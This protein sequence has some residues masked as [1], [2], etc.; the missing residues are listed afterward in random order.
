MR[1]AVYMVEHLKRKNLQCTSSFL[2]GISFKSMTVV[3]TPSTDPIIVPIPKV[4]SITKNKTLQNG[5]PLIVDIASVNA[6]NVKPGPSST[7]KKNI[8]D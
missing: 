8:K 3:L 7:L 4:S 2:S 1:S 6:I 5:V